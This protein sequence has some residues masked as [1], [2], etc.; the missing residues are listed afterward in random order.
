ML[1]FRLKFGKCIYAV[2]KELGID[3][4]WKELSELSDEEASGRIDELKAQLE[5]TNAGSSDTEKQVS[6]INDC[7]LGMCFKLV[8]RGANSSYWQQ[9][10]EMFKREVVA[11]YILAE[12]TEKAVKTAISFHPADNKTDQVT[13]E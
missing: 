12:E 3:V 2:S 5:S 13:E 8:Y 7:R 9:N 10:K 1:R 11:A 4:D 6:Q